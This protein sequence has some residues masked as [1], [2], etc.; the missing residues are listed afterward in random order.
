MAAQRYLATDVIFLGIVIIGILGMI[1]DL[2]L[3]FLYRRL[4]PWM[5]EGD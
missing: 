2:S 4:F 3:K 5:K 1:T